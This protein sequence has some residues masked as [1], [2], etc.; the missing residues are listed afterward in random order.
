MR[1]SGR[2]VAEALE[3]LAEA[4]VAGTTLDALDAIAARIIER[5]GAVS[6][7]LGYHGYPK[8]LCT[9]VNEVVVHGIPGPR[10]LQ[11]G[12]IVGLDFGVSLKG[13]H[14]DAARTVAVGKISPERQR[15]LDVTREALERA[16]AAAVEGNRLGDIGAAVQTYVESE[17]YSIVEDFVGHGIGRQMHEEPQ[18]PNYGLPGRGRRLKTGMVLALE[19][20]VN[21]GTKHVKV[22]AD[23]W[24]VVT[25]DGKDS[26]HFEN[27]VA[28]TV[29]GPEVLTRL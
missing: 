22:L 17:G 11:D 23:D 12:D 2:I 3:T 27:T 9:S 14:A 5:H 4:A 7:F 1:Q 10:V 24:T 15:L 25:V 26:G 28:L 8:V 6:S 13:F 18:V 16:T 29:H 21:I 19:P 20:M